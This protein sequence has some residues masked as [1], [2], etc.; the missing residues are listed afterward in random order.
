MV[1]QFGKEVR[2]A[3]HPEGFYVETADYK[4]LE[5]EAAALRASAQRYE[6]VRRMH[7]EDFTKMWKGNI[8]TGQ[9]FDDLVDQWKG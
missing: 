1:K 9:F 3:E 2:L 8:I 5:A 6:K 7:P 4:A